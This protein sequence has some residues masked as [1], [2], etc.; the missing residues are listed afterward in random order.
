MSGHGDGV[1]EQLYDQAKAGEWDAVL[2][3]FG[4]DP[5]SAAR[6]SRFVKPTSGW[7]F[8]HQAA[9]A[10]H[11]PAARAL[12]G[13]GAA[14]D[15]AAASGETPNGVARRRG[16]VGVMRLIDDAAARGAG[17]WAPSPDQ[18]LMPASSAWQQAQRRRAL[19]TRRVAYGG[20]AV[21]IPAG[22]TYFVDDYERTLIGWH[23]TYDPPS[24]MDGES[25]VAL[26]E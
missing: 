16:H 17:L 12:I 20:G 15:A 21:E 6:C 10:G 2:I 5:T 23:G 4:A 8:L 7:T 24:G 9:Y 13:L 1:V 18:T 3:R 26:R 19:L 25:L 11:S 22:A 14:V